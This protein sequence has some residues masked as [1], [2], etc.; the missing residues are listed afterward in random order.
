M[1]QVP[2]LRNVA[3]APPCFHDGGASSLTQAVREMGPIQLD[4]RLLDGQV[5]AVA[6][7]L[8]TL[9]DRYHDRLLIPSAT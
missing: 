7:L 6:A 5:D 2:S 4:R 9:T 3:V 8:S 1:L